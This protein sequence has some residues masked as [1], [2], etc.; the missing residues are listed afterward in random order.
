MNGANVDDGQRPPFLTLAATA[1]CA[2]IFVAYMLKRAD[3]SSGVLLGLVCPN[4]YELWGGAYWG[5]FTSVFV[6][7][8]LWHIAFNLYWLWV[9]GSVAERTLGTGR[10]LVFFLG[11]ALVSSSLQLAVSNST[12]IGASGV[13]YAIFGL[14]WASRR[15]VPVFEE[16]LG[17]KTPPLFFI[18]LVGCIVVT[19]LGWMNIGNT[20]H[21]SG[22]VFGILVAG[23]LF[24]SERWRWNALGGSALL[25]SLSIV[26]LF[27]CPWSPPWVARQAYDAHIE[28]EYDIAIE[29]Y[30]RYIEM[31]AD[32]SWGLA[33]L[34]LAYY[35]AGDAQQYIATL[36]RL[37]AKYPDAAA[38]FEAS[39]EG[40]PELEVTESE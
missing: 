24:P 2:A 13:G 12:G 36:E 20:A 23:W 16:V 29:H 10:F 15:R 40:A 4:A 17:E 14:M 31:D 33:N 34:A 22:L 39:M 1:A 11:A 9:L 35:N 26:P 28:D 32:R 18:W 27:W 5:L 3:S 21:V 25:V 38:E 7:M 37:R 8:K 6:H 19:Q 30:L